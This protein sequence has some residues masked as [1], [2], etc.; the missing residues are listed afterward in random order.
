MSSKPRFTSTTSADRTGAEIFTDRRVSDTLTACGAV[1][2]APVV[3]V[4][5]TVVAAGDRFADEAA[6][7]RTLTSDL[8]GF[9]DS[10]C[11]TREPLR[12]AAG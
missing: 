5:D 4:L 7:E 10:R 3:G 12:T 8:R 1:P 11:D 2:P 6:S 9:T